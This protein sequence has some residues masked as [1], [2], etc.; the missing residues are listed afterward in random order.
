MK[1]KNNLEIGKIFLENNKNKNGIVSLSSGLQY[2]ILES[3]NK[4]GQSPKITD[5]VLCHYEGRHI[6]GTIFDSSYKTG[7]PLEISLLEVISGWTIAL[8]MMKEGDK[9]EIFLPSEFAYGRQGAGKDIE[10]DSTL[11]FIVELI[12]IK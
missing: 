11:I 4:E 10:P 3:K 5:S 7:K 12:K 6:D 1:T 2:K 8:Q 9:W